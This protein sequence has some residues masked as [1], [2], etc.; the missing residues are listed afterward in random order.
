MLVCGMGEVER[1][2]GRAEGAGGR[3]PGGQ[4]RQR[5]EQPRH[6]GAAQQWGRCHLPPSLSLSPVVPRS[7]Q[8][9]GDT[10]GRIHRSALCCS[11][12]AGAQWSPSLTC[13]LPGQSRPSTSQVPALGKGQPALRGL[14]W[15]AFTC[16]G[17]LLLSIPHIDQ[18]IPHTSFALAVAQG[19]HRASSERA[20]TP[21]LHT[22]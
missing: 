14:T 1:D 13:A 10:D 9:R 8:S 11:E 21:Q 2:V 7:A 15:R 16:N 19:G 6:T 22:G 17:K 4:Q 5:G 3:N 12:S 18:S 20:E